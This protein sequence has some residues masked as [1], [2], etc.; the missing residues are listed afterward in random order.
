VLTALQHIFRTISFNNKIAF[1]VALNFPKYSLEEKNAL[2]AEWSNL[3]WGYA[4]LGDL[5]T[6][7]VPADVLQEYNKV[8]SNARLYISEYNIFAG[9]LI[10]NEGNTLFPEGMKLLSHWNIR[11]EI[12]SNYDRADGT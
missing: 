3:E 5:Y 6:A 9:K 11:D 10:N 2:G 12:K 4:R 7:R 8:Y 1:V